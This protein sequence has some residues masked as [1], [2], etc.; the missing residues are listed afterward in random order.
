MRFRSLLTKAVGAKVA[1][2]RQ[3]C[4]PLKTQS[5]LASNVGVSRAAISALEAGHQGV[6]LAVLCRIALTFEISPSSLLPDIDELRELLAV[7]KTD[8][9]EISLNDIVNRF[10]E[11]G[12]HG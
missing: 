3:R 5:E 9:Q 2:A 11:E 8:T 7:S 6:S 1:D 4:K 12:D 10:V